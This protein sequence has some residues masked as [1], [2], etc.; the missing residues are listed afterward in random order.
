MDKAFANAFCTIAAA[1][2]KGCWEGFLVHE[3][4]K[5][6]VKLLDRSAEPPFSVYASEVEGNFDGTVV[7]GGL[8]QWAWVSRE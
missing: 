8:N 2:T 5:R 6:S 7:K 1:S 4:V 3:Q